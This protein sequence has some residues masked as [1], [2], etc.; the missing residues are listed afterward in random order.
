MIA[1]T[2]PHKYYS[3]SDSQ[4]CQLLVSQASTAIVTIIQ[5]NVFQFLSIHV[6]KGLFLTC[7]DDTRQNIILSAV[8][9]VSR[10]L[11]TVAY[12]GYRGLLY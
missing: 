6:C 4:C 9:T 2:L 10:P 3:C 7:I 1:S 8:G 5:R 12:A 11:S